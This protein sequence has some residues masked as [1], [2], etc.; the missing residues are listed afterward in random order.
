MTRRRL[1]AAAVV[2]AVLVQMAFVAS[3]HSAT[4]G[5][6]C[7]V[8]SQRGPPPPY[9][10]W[11]VEVTS[12]PVRMLP[13]PQMA[14]TPELFP[15]LSEEAASWITVLVFAWVNAVFWTTGFYALLT[16]VAFLFRVRPGFRLASLASVRPLWMAMAMLAIVAAGLAGG[17]LYHRWWMSSAKDAVRVAFRTLHAGEHLDAGSGY[18][19]SCYDCQPEQL[20]GEYTLTHTAESEGTHPLDA[21]VPPT[22][23]VARARFANGARY[24]AHIFYIDGTW[25]VIVTPLKPGDP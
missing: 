7:A 4:G 9:I 25:S 18:E 11:T 10:A 6:F 1:W 17:A 19:I 5:C 14:I 13:I 3:Y 21:F 15:G 16:A 24:G 20:A 8:L 22:G 23:L 2:L 12:L